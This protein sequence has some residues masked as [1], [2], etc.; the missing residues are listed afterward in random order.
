MSDLLNYLFQNINDPYQRII[1]IVIFML[2]MD[3]FTALFAVLMS[4]GRR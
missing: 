3:M 4:R 1:V 2:F